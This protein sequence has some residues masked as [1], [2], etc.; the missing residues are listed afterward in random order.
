VIGSA[1]KNVGG[2]A[3]LALCVVGSGYNV[4]MAVNSPDGTRMNS[5]LKARIEQERVALAA[6]KAEAAALSDHADRLERES[7]DGDLL[8]ERVRSRLGLVARDEYLVR[9]EDL[10]RLAGLSS[11]PR[12]DR[13]RIAAVH[14]DGPTT[15]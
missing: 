11:H 15:R 10:D 5:V 13:T 9:M 12:P 4:L 3:L 8:E 2:A 1:L 7:L 6:L 14:T